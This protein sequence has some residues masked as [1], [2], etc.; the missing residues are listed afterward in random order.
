MSKLKILKTKLAK[1][2]FRTAKSAGFSLVEIMIVLAILGTIMGL[3]AQRIGKNRQKAQR[4]EAVIQMQNIADALS[5]YYNDCGHYPKSLKG[6]IEADPE[7]S[8]WTD[9][10]YKG[11]T[12]DP[13]GSDFTYE[14]NGSDFILKSFGEDKREGGTGLAKD[15]IY[16]EDDSA[17]KKE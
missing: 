13:W 14:L 5:M 6:L 3:V 2:I 17:P 10:Y 16:G 8:N 15:I 11:K 1:N 9:A 7:C 4:K 12:V